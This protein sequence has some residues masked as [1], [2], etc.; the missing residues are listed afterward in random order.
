MKEIWKPVRNYEGKYMVSNLGNVKSL[1]YNRT[2]EEGILRAGKR[3]DGYLYVNLCKEGI[4]KTYQIH[5]LVAESFLPNPNN[6]PCVNHKNELKA[7]NRLENL[8]YCSYSYNNTYNGRAK[9][10]GKKIAEKQRGRK[11]SEETKKKIGEKLSKPVIAINK[12]SGLIVEFPSAME[13]ERTLGIAHSS[14]I[15][16]CKGKLK[17][18]GGYYWHY[19]D[20]SEEVANEQE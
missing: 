10:A 16:C 8:E 6:L 4:M 20:E 19:A 9:K 17:S 3:K 14:I 7:D 11:Q 5:R 1:N 2:G 15:K 18:S 13:A 12:V